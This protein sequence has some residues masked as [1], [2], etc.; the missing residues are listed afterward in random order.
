MRVKLASSI[1]TE[2]RFKLLGREL[3]K[4][5]KQAVG[6]IFL[7]WLA[8]YE[9]R[10]VRLTIAEAD[11]AAEHDGFAQALVRVGLAHSSS[12]GEQIVVH[13]VEQ[14]I[15]FLIEQQERGAKGGK[16]SAKSRSGGGSA[17]NGGA[18]A[19]P[20]A[21]ASRAAQ[22][23][24]PDLSPDHTP[25]PAL[26]PEH[27]PK[28]DFE[29]LYRLYPRKAGRKRGL[30][31][32]PRTIR[33]HDDFAVAL[34]CVEAMAVAWAGQDMTYCPQFDT[35]IRQERWRDEVP[36]MPTPARASSANGHA[37]AED[38]AIGHLKHTAEQKYVGGH[39]V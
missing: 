24:S 13:G 16:S 2:P 39:R 7:V 30:E 36:P 27:M 29:Q 21:N 1:A 14:R 28:F 35:F 25:S 3:G 6:S 34:A 23:Y 18:Q 12:N 20:E 26:A 17:G 15:R 22:A 37:D 31:A 38:P 32:A 8:C 4:D 33:S 11:I 19:P 9:R 5:W 10:S